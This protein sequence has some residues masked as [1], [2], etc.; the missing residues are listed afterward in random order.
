MSS[1]SLVSQKQRLG[2]IIVLGCW[3]FSNEHLEPAFTYLVC[4]TPDHGH[5]CPSLAQVPSV[6]TG[7]GP[8]T[9]Q[10]HCLLSLR[11]ISFFIKSA[12]EL[13]WPL[14]YR[15][16]L[17]QTGR[18]DQGSYYSW[19]NVLGC[20]QSPFLAPSPLSCRL[21]PLPSALLRVTCSGVALLWRPPQLT[22]LCPDGK[23]RLSECRS[24]SSSPGARSQSRPWLRTPWGLPCP[25][26]GLSTW[27]G[28][29][30]S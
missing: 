26:L 7:A 21:Y 8:V 25:A 5:P 12:C 11:P 3:G 29:P 6:Q 2:P 14:I 15:H 10:R 30:S 22:L 17:S 18:G 20:L 1:G 9:L 4:S 27:Q 23:L 24:P 13:I 16:G 19:G 28:F